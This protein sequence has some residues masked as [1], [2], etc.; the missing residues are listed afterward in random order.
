MTISLHRHFVEQVLRQPSAIRAAVFDAMLVLPEAFRH[1]GRHTGLGLRKLHASG[2]WEE[3]IG[4]ELR[5]LIQMA[6]DTAV[7]R[8]L[9]THDEVRKY[10][11]NL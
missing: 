4:L 8:L 6:P 7:L 11:K 10:L 9:G 5:M 1:P 2:V 3:R